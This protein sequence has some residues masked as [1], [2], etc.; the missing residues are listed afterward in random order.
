MLKENKIVEHEVA[1]IHNTFTVPWEKSKMVSFGSSIKK[2]IVAHSAR[3]RF[4][5]KLICYIAFGSV[6][7]ACCLLK[8]I[9]IIF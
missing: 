4:P 5:L 3:S 9:T 1:N 7:S 2:N 6:S 8:Y